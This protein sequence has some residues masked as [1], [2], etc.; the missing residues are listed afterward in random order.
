MPDTNKLITFA[1]PCYNAAEYME[2]CIKTLL[3]AG[4][5]SEIL[6]IDDGS[7]DATGSIADR[8][9]RQYPDRVIAHHQPNGGHGEGV[10]QGIRRAHGEYFKVVD[11]DDWLD[12]DA[13]KKVMDR[14]RAFSAA[15]KAGYAP[16]DLMICNYVYEHVQDGTHHTIS[17]RGILPRNKEFTW[18]QIG[19]FPPSQN[20]LMHSVIY[21]TELLR[22]CGL[23]LPKHTFYVDNLYVYQPL[24]SV[25]TIYYMPLELYHYYI[26]REDQSVN[27]KVMI[28]RIDQQLYITRLM[29]RAVDVYA[30]P[31]EQRKLRRYMLNY[32][33]MM[34]AIS[35]IFL[36]LD[37]SEEALQKRKALWCELRRYDKRLYRR[38]IFS[39]AGACYLPGDSGLAL[40]RTGY[41]LAQKIFKFN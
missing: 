2:R 27:E 32:F 7:T 39:V 29:M 38:C 19:I 6:L 28:K 37:G 33:S 10:N 8:Y 3:P 40:S 23:E 34:M 17:Y 26:G 31:P 12:P 24:P 18:K 21:R 41:R 11:S 4:D 1:V 25:E 9:A 16:L 15:E 14:L 20:I 35:S 5:D 36:D 13:L 22:E 30:L